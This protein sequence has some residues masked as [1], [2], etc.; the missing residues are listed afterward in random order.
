MILKLQLENIIHDSLEKLAVMW[1]AWIGPFTYPCLHH[2]VLKTRK[3][4]SFSVQTVAFQNQHNVVSTAP[5]N[6]DWPVDL[7][8]T[9][10]S[11]ERI[12]DR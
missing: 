10:M 11:T 6:S 1:V 8:V 12:E 5:C 3:S 7:I 9:P 4:R 2:A